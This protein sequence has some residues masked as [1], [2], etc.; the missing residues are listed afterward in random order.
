MG[1]LSSRSGFARCCCC[2]L[3]GKLGGWVL[4]HCCRCLL[5][6]DAPLGILRLPFLC[7]SCSGAAF[8]YASSPEE[9]KR[10]TW[11][12]SPVGGSGPGRPRLRENR[13]STGPDRST[14][15]PV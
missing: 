10:T 9:P 4:V 12:L 13:R 6:S 15:T 14:N 11:V 2:H 3:W 7:R 5:R 8:L 1:R